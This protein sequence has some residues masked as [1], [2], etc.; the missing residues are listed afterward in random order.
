METLLGDQPNL[1]ALFAELDQTVRPEELKAEA[2]ADRVL[3]GFRALTKM[4]DLP[5]R[6]SKIASGMALRGKSNQI[7]CP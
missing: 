3:P 5:D 4:D 1:P 6:L 7:V 2:D